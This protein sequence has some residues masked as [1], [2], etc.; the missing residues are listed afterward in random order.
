MKKLILFLIVLSVSSCSLD[1]TKDCDDKLQKLEDLRSK[2]W[3][4][5]N[6]SASCVQKIEKDYE[7]NKNEVLRNCN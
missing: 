3:T 6:G 1:D 2:G 4:N 7:K 5:C